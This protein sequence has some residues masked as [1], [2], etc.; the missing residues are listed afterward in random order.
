MLKNTLVSPQWMAVCTPMPSRPWR[1]LRAGGEY[2]RG[3]DGK[4]LTFKTSQAA[5]AKA[6][7]LGLTIAGGVEP[8]LPGEV[9]S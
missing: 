1:L 3:D 6:A 7:S 9:E 8:A 2:V 4:A 5:C